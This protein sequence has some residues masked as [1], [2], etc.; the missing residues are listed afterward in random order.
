MLE[1]QVA[2][3]E[4]TLDMLTSLIAS[5]AE[6]QNLDKPDLDSGKWYTNPQE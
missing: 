1:I 6:T 4:V 5:M 3:L 2:R